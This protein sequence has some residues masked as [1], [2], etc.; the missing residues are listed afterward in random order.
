MTLTD[1]YRYRAAETVIRKSEQAIEAM[2]ARRPREASVTQGAGSPDDA[3]RVAFDEALYRE[4]EGALAM[5]A[6]ALAELES[7]GEG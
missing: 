5:A 7:A 6:A 2:Q 3:E 1:D 4:T